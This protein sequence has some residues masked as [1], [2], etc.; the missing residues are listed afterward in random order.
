MQKSG[1]LQIIDL[2]C[3]FNDYQLL[4]STLLSPAKWNANSKATLLG[5]VCSIQNAKLSHTQYYEFISSFILTLKA[6]EKKETQLGTYFDHKAK[7]YSNYPI[8]V[9]LRTTQEYSEALKNNNFSNFSQEEAFQLQDAD[10][11][12][13]WRYLGD[14]NIYWGDY[15]N[16]KTM[17][18]RNNKISSILAKNINDINILSKKTR[19]ESIIQNVTAETVKNI[20]DTEGLNDIKSVLTVS[21]KADKTKVELPEFGVSVTYKNA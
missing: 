7:E 19:L 12:Y 10:I 5:R 4:Q 2:E 17:R 21:T 3:V 18:Y 20:L 8:R 1:K 11:P 13:F 15:C 14:Q 9:L 16:R 6:F